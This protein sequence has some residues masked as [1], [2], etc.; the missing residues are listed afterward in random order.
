MNILRKL[1][2]E[3]ID[4]Y[5]L[6]LR[7]S[8]PE[9]FNVP[10]KLSIV[11]CN[12][13]LSKLKN[14]FV[15]VNENWDHIGIPGRD[16]SAATFYNSSFANCVFDDCKLNYTKFYDQ[17]V[18]STKFFYV[19][20]RDSKFRGCVI[21]QSNF[22]Y[23]DLLG[24]SFFDCTF[25]N[26]IFHHANLCNTSFVNCIFENC[27]F[28]ASNMFNCNL[29]RCSFTSTNLC[30]TNLTKAS[31]CSCDMRDMETNEATMGFH[32]TC[33]EEGAFIGWKRVRDNKFVKLWISD[34]ARR[35]SSTS[36]KCRCDK[37]FVLGIYDENKM[38]L[39]NV[40]RVYSIHDESFVY[41]VNKVAHV[42]DFNE[43]RWQECASG[44]HFFMTFEE[45]KQYNM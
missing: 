32:N 45:A 38:F 26:V 17:H 1:I 10:E 20:M 15:I 18:T 33:P 12:S 16:I 22:S 37:A 28:Q 8:R 42:D 34:E 36:R 29:E 21:E 25:K 3:R 5:D 9:I 24:A 31:I 6:T 41:E 40:T 14:K 39:P 30:F 2:I 43:N 4:D 11:Q 27:A 7:N 19:V 35:S 23:S 44:I 13:N